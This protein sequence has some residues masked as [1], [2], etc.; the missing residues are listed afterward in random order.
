MAKGTYSTENCGPFLL[1]II[2][3]SDLKQINFGAV[4]AEHGINAHSAYCR[5]HG[6]K[7]AMK[8]EL[9]G[10]AADTSP[11]RGR[12]RGSPTKASKNKKKGVKN[13]DK[14]MI[15]VSTVSD[16]SDVDDEEKELESPTKKVKREVEKKEVES[17]EESYYE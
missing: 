16:G 3:H 1:S 4:G 6:I 11:K 12:K 2:K 5:F 9:E 14:D 10:E 17:D 13:E 15:K 7:K 8:A